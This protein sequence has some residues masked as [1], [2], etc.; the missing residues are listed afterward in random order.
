MIDRRVAPDVDNAPVDLSSMEFW[1]LPPAGREKG[2]A[3]LLGRF[4]EPFTTAGRDG[5]RM[6]APS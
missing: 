5:S 6:P 1:A 2:F 3:E 4:P